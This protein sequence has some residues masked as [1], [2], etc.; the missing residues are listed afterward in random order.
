MFNGFSIMTLF[1]AEFVHTDNGVTCSERGFKDLSTAQECSDAVSYAKTFNSEA[2]YR[3]EGSL[4]S[5]PKG[6][7]ILGAG[8][9]VF[10]THSTGGRQPSATS[11]C[12]KGNT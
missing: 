1:F 10:N 8:N 9:M 11:I 2:H 7:Y 6:C 5:Y 4:K 3:K 12:K